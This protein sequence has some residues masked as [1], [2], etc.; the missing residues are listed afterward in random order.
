MFPF[1]SAQRRRS[2]E[3]KGNTFRSLSLARAAMSAGERQRGGTS[4]TWPTRSLPGIPSEAEQR[5][6][7]LSLGGGSHET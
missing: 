3:Q 6:N 1:C 5:I 4:K 7:L 2:A